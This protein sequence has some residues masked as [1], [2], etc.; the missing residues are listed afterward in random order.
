MHGQTHARFG[1]QLC[2]QSR[3]NKTRHETV[4]VPGGTNQL[5]QPPSRRHD[6]A[7]LKQ[8][9]H[10]HDSKNGPLECDMFLDYIHEQIAVFFV[11]LST[12]MGKNIVFYNIGFRGIAAPILDNADT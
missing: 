4:W 12:A 6:G 8:H 1:N 11:G 9:P 3:S 2:A 5:T 7:P 10:T